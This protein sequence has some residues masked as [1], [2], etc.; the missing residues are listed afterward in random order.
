MRAQQPRFISGQRDP[1][2]TDRKDLQK[3][4]ASKLEAAALRRNSTDPNLRIL[5]PPFVWLSLYWCGLLLLSRMRTAFTRSLRIPATHVLSV[6]P[7]T[8]AARPP[9]PLLAHAQP[10]GRQ[11][12]WRKTYLAGWFIDHRQDERFAHPR[13]H[14]EFRG[15][16]LYSHNGSGSRG[17]GG[18][19]RVS[20]H[21]AVQVVLNEDIKAAMSLEEV[22]NLCMEEIQHFNAVNCSQAFHALGLQVERSRHDQTMSDEEWQSKYDIV[23]SAVGALNERTL[24]VISELE[25]R[26]LGSILGAHVKMGL[27]PDGKVRPASYASFLPCARSSVTYES[28][29]GTGRD[30]MT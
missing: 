23:A 29:A 28:G 6:Q 9:F 4:S 18:R 5:Q 17:R 10:P 26:H 12:T 16:R 27:K 20:G 13:A 19:R 30:G 24:S 25:R 8:P 1:Q 11:A 2:L 14:G 21:E 3:S 7:H 22:C 15:A